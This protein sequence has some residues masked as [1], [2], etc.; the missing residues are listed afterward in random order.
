[1]RIHIYIL[2]AILASP[3]LSKANDEM[4]KDIQDSLASI[5]SIGS[6]EWREKVEPEADKLVKKYGSE[7]AGPMK[8]LVLADAPDDVARQFGLAILVKL[9][10]NEPVKQTLLDILKNCD[11]RAK[12]DVVCAMAKIKKDFAREVAINSINLAADPKV[13]IAV[14]QLLGVIGD[15]NTVAILRGIERKDGEDADVK[16]AA[17]QAREY[18]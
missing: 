6:I 8:T 5:T 9:G 10:A 18:L 12:N 1:M 7:L 15:S 2:L 14:V 16:K 11:S 3:S 17:L 4:D 13:E